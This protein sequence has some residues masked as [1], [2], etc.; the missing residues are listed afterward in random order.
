LSAS[1]AG[2]AFI[3]PCFSKLASSPTKNGEYLA[4]GLPLIIN[5]G[6][7]DSDSLIEREGVG[8]LV[9]DLTRTE[10]AVAATTILRVLE[11]PNQAQLHSREVAKRL[12]DVIG[13]GLERYATLYDEILRGTADAP[14]TEG[15]A[16]IAR[17]A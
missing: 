7:G 8:A 13:I 9:S 3:K 10:Y 1:D 4:C 5:A 6:I 14:S 16:V 15:A 2:I 11:E 12:F 17:E